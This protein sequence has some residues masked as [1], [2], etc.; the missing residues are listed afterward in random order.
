MTDRQAPA[1]SG[2][3]ATEQIPR[4]K[5]AQ[6]LHDFTEFNAEIP[7][8]I[9]VVAPPGRQPDEAGFGLVAE[10]RPLLDVTLDEEAGVPVI[11]IECGDPAAL[12]SSEKAPSALRHLCR[13]PT[14]LW[15]RK[16]GGS[17]GAAGW[18]AI[19]IEGRESSVI[20]SLA[21]QPGSGLPQEGATK[22][23]LQAGRSARTEE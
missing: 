10:N 5:W 6:F 20:V 18:D 4:E 19:E 8:R 1:T 11:V 21:P 7:A 13:N 17:P 3:A 12:S 22:E 2:D 15:A 14:A 9:Q 16:S 23:L